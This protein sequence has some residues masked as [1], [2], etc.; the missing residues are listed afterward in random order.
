M[1]RV[2]R[3][4][5][6]VNNSFSFEKFVRFF[7]AIEAV[8][9]Y[10][11][12]KHIATF[13]VQGNRFW[14]LVTIV[15]LV[16]GVSLMLSWTIERNWISIIA[17]TILP[18]LVYET[19][20][21]WRYFP[22]IRVI[23]IVGTSSAFVLGVYLA[24]KRTNRIKRITIKRKA[25]I[26]KTAFAARVFL[27]LVLLISCVYGKIMIS[28]HYT[29]SFS[30]ISYY[31]SDDHENIPDYENS[32]DANLDVI[33]QLDPDGGWN[34]LSMED[35]ENVLSACVRVECR[36]LGMRD[37]MPSLELAYMEEGL[38]GE[39][40]PSTDTVTIS[41]ILIRDCNSGYPLVQCL[42]HE[43][44][45]RYQHRVVSLLED[46]RANEDTEKYV[47][48]LMLNSALVYEEEFDHYY[49]PTD[50]SALSYYLYSSQQVERDAEK[51]GNASMVEYYERIQEY[52]KTQ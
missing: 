44:Y 3:H 40:N 6:I 15:A 20:S 4:R 36:Y 35:I 34:S 25:C 21:L 7:I 16:A 41:Y 26:I 19:V 27:C 13:S 10:L 51:Y 18:I 17:G 23:T 12:I 8:L 48:L 52:L 31:L 24:A 47:D 33:C 14:L 38:L 9:T 49:S 1:E 37:S 46:L 45:H 42:A 50:D 30:D 29:V 43:V 22:V 39:Y 32:L 28:T 11:Y 2:K 5:K